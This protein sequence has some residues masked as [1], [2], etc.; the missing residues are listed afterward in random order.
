MMPS[1]EDVKSMFAWQ[2]VE[3]GKA[4]AVHIMLLT[5][6]SQDME[7][8]VKKR[9]EPEVTKEMQD[10]RFSQ[11]NA[12]NAKEFQGK[13]NSEFQEWLSRISVCTSKA[14]RDLA[15]TFYCMQEI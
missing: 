1:S 7:N 4:K 2:G 6:P 15:E 11:E 5:I 10:L 12:K 9:K 14:P 8:L 3:R 13:A